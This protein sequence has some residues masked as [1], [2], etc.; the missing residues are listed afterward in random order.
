MTNKERERLR[1]D[2]SL[3]REVTEMLIL[4]G[5]PRREYLEKLKDYKKSIRSRMNQIYIRDEEQKEIVQYEEDGSGW[6][7]KEWY[8]FHFTNE[9]KEEY[10]EANWHH[11]NCAFDCTGRVF[12]GWI[13]IF[14][15]ETSFGA[16]SVVYH[17]KRLDV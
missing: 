2:I 12:T 11:T 10:I 4:Q 6:I 9:D 15:V 1:A 14:N 17:A 5:T 3:L 13:S 16:K 8:D 7:E